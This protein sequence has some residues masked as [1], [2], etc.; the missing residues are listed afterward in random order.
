[1]VSQAYAGAGSVAGSSGDAGVEFRRGV[2]AYAVAHALAAAPLPGL[3]I[4]AAAGL[5]QAVTLETEDAVDDLRIDFASGWRAQVQAKRTLAMGGVLAKAVGQWR[6]AGLEALDPEKDRLVIVAGTVRGGAKD[7]QYALERLRFSTSGPPTAKQS[8]AQK[9]MEKLLIPLSIDQLEIVLRCALIWELPVE[10]PDQ[11]GAQAAISQLRHVVATG[12]ADGA[13][14]AWRSLLGLTGRAARLRAGHDLAGWRTALLGEGVALLRAEG[15]LDFEWLRDRADET[16]R[17][18]GERYTKMLTVKVPL[19]QVIEGVARSPGA[20]KPIRKALRKSLNLLGRLRVDEGAPTAWCSARERL[21]SLE[22]EVS[23][24]DGGK[25]LPA[26]WAVECS[27]IT[28]LLIAA[29][30][31]AEDRLAEFLDR[32]ATTLLDAERWLASDTAAAW[33]NKALLISGEPG[34]GKSHLLADTTLAALDRGQPAVLLLGQQFGRREPWSQ[35]R[36][37]L[38]WSGTTDQFL[39]AL[40]DLAS[41]RNCRALLMIDA[42]NEGEMKDAWTSHLATFLTRVARY[43]S[44]AVVLTVRSAA[45]GSCVS[46]GA[47]EL[48]YRVEHRGFIGVEFNAVRAYF[49]HH[50]LPPPSEPLVLTEFRNPLFLSI[51]CRVA[52]ARPNLLRESLPGLSTVLETYLDVLDGPVCALTGA[53]PHDQVV[54]Q[55]CM[56]LAGKMH[57]AGTRHLQRAEVKQVLDDVHRSQSYPQSLLAGLL[58]ER[59][60]AEDYVNTATGTQPVIRFTFERLADHLVA[61]TLL[62]RVRR[63]DGSFDLEVLEEAVEAIP[64]GSGTI[65]ALASYLPEQTGVELVEAMTPRDGRE[66]AVLIDR[67]L[68]SLPFRIPEKMT[69]TAEQLL[70]TA[71]LGPDRRRARSAAGIAI[72]VACRSGHLL[73]ADW[74]HRTLQALPMSDRDATWSVAISDMGRSGRTPYVWLQRWLQTEHQTAVEELSAASARMVAITVMWSFTSPDRFLRDQMTR[75]LV[76]LTSAHA[77][78]LPELLR[79]A[80]EIDD[81]Y[82]LERVCAVVYGT[83]LRGISVE[84]LRAV[85]EV[86]SDE[87]FAGEPPVHVLVRDY[88]RGVMRL[89]RQQGLL[90]DDAWRRAEGPWSS[91]WP[92]KNI[93]TQAELERDYPA[94]TESNPTGGE[95][96][97]N[98]LHSGLLGYGDFG[99]KIIGTDQGHSFPFT[100]A[101]APWLAKASH[102]LQNDDEPEV[103]ASL[104]EQWLQDPEL[105]DALRAQLQSLLDHSARAASAA[106]ARRPPPFD[107]KSVSRFVFA[108]VVERGWTPEKFGEIDSRLARGSGDTGRSSHKRERIAKKYQWQAWHEAYARLLDT[109]E[110]RDSYGLPVAPR[111][112]IAIDRVRDID[113]THLLT[114]NPSGPSDAEDDGEEPA[115]YPEPASPDLTTWDQHTLW[116]AD[117]SA[118]YDTEALN[119]V[120]GS[121]LLRTPA[122]RALHLDPE[123]QWVVLS[124]TTAWNWDLYGR[125][126]T[127]SDDLWADHAIVEH[128]LLVKTADTQAALG[129]APQRY[130]GFKF[131]SEFFDGPFLGEVP[132][133]PHY[134]ALLEHRDLDGVNDDGFGVDIDATDTVDRYVWEGGTYD[135]SLRGTVSVS[136]PSKPLLDLLAPGAKVR[137]GAT[138]ALD[139]TLI[140]FSPG[141]FQANDDVDLFVREDPLRTALLGSGLALMRVVFQERRG[142]TDIRVRGKSAGMRTRTSVHVHEPL[143]TGWRLVGSAPHHDEFMEPGVP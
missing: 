34:Q 102:E 71:M 2:A 53:D 139:G 21:A 15:A 6:R 89:A 103:Q 42:L 18:V 143:E 99:I 101:P 7:L 49:A 25:E 14:Q 141:V 58:N 118:L 83:A 104:L 45:E 31:S 65:D 75:W 100:P 61:V 3:G 47:R 114:G 69:P 112:D 86:L 76:R 24:F 17:Q 125:T 8:K 93:P 57:S 26:G 77:G 81:I 135:C 132:D 84:Q 123:S 63:G 134:T 124:S 9:Y 52:K 33:D 28:E 36:E 5:V 106:S 85:A 92:G 110:L 94:F 142:G 55:A 122:G 109:H 50:Q 48:L 91:L 37:L 119:F 70:R 30:Y 67:I 54:R 126:P 11:P 96:L 117:A 130:D 128:A 88:A 129:K 111:I 131:R 107:T 4:P 138:R 41:A 79:L 16:V 120:A 38:N 62:A 64:A 20:L 136:F 13:L 95:R 97:W 10:E 22:G 78:L 35:V 23:A 72:S 137:D 127:I 59:I 121:D 1:M 27:E 39:Q 116:V 115:L 140:A 82:V 32:T 98:S 80:V 51:Y 19:G 40:D 87:L 105:D 133:Q 43:R 74:L 113:P 90:S 12:T 60:L 44:I 73:D 68:Q 66:R 46:A 29:A 56:R 108:G